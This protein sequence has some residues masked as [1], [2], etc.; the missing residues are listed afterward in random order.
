MKKEDP[1]IVQSYISNPYLIRGYKVQNRHMISFL[2]LTH[3]N[4]FQFDFRIYV[5]VTSISPLRI[6]LYKNGLVR[7]ATDKFSTDPEVTFAIQ[8]ASLQFINSKTYTTN[9]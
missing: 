6:Y 3:L 2:V 8:R 5:L 7:F 4:T 1:I 9:L